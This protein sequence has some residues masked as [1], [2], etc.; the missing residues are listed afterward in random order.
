M[1]ARSG[2]MEGARKIDEALFLRFSFFLEK[3]SM[4]QG[5]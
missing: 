1:G 4:R 2:S 5:L 3:G